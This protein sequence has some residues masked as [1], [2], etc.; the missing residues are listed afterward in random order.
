MAEDACNTATVFLERI[1]SIRQ[2]RRD[3]RR[4][5]HKPLVLLFALARASRGERDRL[6]PYAAAREPLRRLLMEF[7]PTPREKVYHSEYPFVRLQ[8]DGIWETRLPS[9]ALFVAEGDPSERM[10][11]DLG[12]SGGLP[13]EVHRA[14]LEQPEV[15]RRAAAF[16]LEENFP[17]TLHEEILTEIGFHALEGGSWTFRAR[18]D[19]AF[20]A[21]VLLAYEFRCAV[22][23]FHL[24]MDHAP[25]GLDP[26]ETGAR[27]RR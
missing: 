24:Q 26:V 10:L 11:L 25:I 19:P 23:G 8:N 2:H 13:A 15:V 21:R 7:G 3:G 17:D 5:V 27:T 9:G 14:L 16:L 4:A 1:K 12:V 20:R 18:R 22:C 6:V